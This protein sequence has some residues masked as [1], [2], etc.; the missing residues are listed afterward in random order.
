[1]CIKDEDTL[2]CSLFLLLNKKHHS[3]SI[4]KDKE[5]L[6]L[7]PMMFEILLTS[8]LVSLQERERNENSSRNEKGH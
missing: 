6:V 2:L 4:D 5:D 1:M 8:D 7:V 3:V